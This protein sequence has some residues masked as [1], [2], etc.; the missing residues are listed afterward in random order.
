MW[1]EVFKVPF[2]ALSKWGYGGRTVGESNVPSTGGVILASNH[3][4]AIDTYV[5]PALMRRRVTFP[6]KAEL[7]DGDRGWQSKLVAWFLKAV[8]QVPLDRSGGR[9]SMDGLGPVVQAV[10]DGQVAGIFPEGSRSPD[11]RLYKGKTGVARL[12]ML[13]G[14][15][16]V[17]VGV[18]DTQITGKKLG[19]VPWASRPVIRFGT[20]LDFSEYADRADDRALVRWI[21]DEIMAAIQELTGQTYVNAYSTS[22]KYGGMAPD[23]VARRTLPRP[24]G[25]P[26]P[27]PR[28]R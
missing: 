21:T 18:I 10:T 24:G 15:P 12:A 17:P 27:E 19:V 2:R 28:A 9:A 1:Y 13:T 7:F 23:E 4:S 3:V 16:V 20:P 26:A 5:M 8:G 6:A 25:G 22:V 14:A 11:G